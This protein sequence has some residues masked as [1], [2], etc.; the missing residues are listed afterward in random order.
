M[1]CSGVV[2]GCQDGAGQARAGEQ[3]GSKASQQQAP[4]NPGWANEAETHMGARLG[5]VDAIAAHPQANQTEK[6]AAETRT[7]LGQVEA[8]AAHHGGGQHHGQRVGLVLA[9]NVGRRAVHLRWRVVEGAACMAVSQ[10]QQ[11]QLPAAAA[12]AAAALPAAAAQAAAL[13]CHIPGARTGS[14]TPGLPGSEMEADGS[15]PRLP[16]SMLASSDRMSPKMLPGG[17]ER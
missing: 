10:P 8:V 1:T 5:Q 14:Y 11:R 4:N 6:A 16:V 15:M 13:H 9:S 7:H 3:V 17:G 12:A 2:R